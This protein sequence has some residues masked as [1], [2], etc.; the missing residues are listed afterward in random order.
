MQHHRHYSYDES[1]AGYGHSLPLQHGNAHSTPG[2]Q[3]LYEHQ[4]NTGQY[5]PPIHPAMG[6]ANE[7]S[8]QCYQN[9]LPNMHHGSRYPTEHTNDPRYYNSQSLPTSSPTSNSTQSSYYSGHYNTSADPRSQHAHHAH[10]IPT[11]SELTQ[12]ANYPHHIRS[13]QSPGRPPEQYT[14]NQDCKIPRGPLQQQ[15]GISTPPRPRPTPGSSPTATPGERFLCDKCGKTFSRSHDRK[16]HHETQHLPT[17]IIHRCRYC[18]K[19]FSRLVVFL[20]C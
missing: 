19:E 16:R 10:F 3:N 4:Q 1:S 17:P 9:T 8:N 7:H 20:A 11:P 6:N 14:T 18:E 2:H 5:Y 13:P 12:Y 15:T